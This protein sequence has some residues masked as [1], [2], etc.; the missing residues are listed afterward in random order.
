MYEYDYPKEQ[1]NMKIVFVIPSLGMGGAENSLCD[2]ANRWSTNHEITVVT[3]N[4]GKDFF[5]LQ[6]NVDR[7]SVNIRRK[8]WWNIQ[9]HLNTLFKIRAIIRDRKPHFVISFLVK[10][11]IFTILSSMGLP[12]PV[13]ISERNMINRR[14]VDIRQKIL[15]FIFYGFAEKICVLSDSMRSDLTSSL[16]HIN[17]SKIHI[18]PN[19]IKLLSKTDTGQSI[20]SF[21]PHCNSLSSVVISLGRLVPQKQF[22]QLIAAFSLLHKVKPDTGLI[23]FGDGPERRNLEKQVADLDISTYVSLPGRTEHVA[24]FLQQSDVFVMTSAFEGM[25]GA[26]VEAMQCGVPSVV[27][28]APGI[29]DLMEGGENGIIVDMNDIEKLAQAIRK[30][31]TDKEMA[32]NYADKAHNYI[33]SFT[34]ENID[35]IWFNTVLVS[36]G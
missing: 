30:M 21:L 5:S 29:S 34:P 18:V 31:L 3:L 23:I 20:Q 24:H 9:A 14:D 8:K 33:L 28:N 36:A 26:L 6:D 17:P 4:P 25:P 12:V 2:L 11:N 1:K 16:P 27:Y 35:D 13:I 15:R 10:A 19:S 22:D 32:K 7:I